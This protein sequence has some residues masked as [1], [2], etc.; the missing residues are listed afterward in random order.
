MPSS[1]G[2]F[3]VFA[4]SAD[5]APPG[6]IAWEPIAADDG[7]LVLPHEHA[8]RVRDAYLAENGPKQTAMM[9]AATSDG[10]ETEIGRRIRQGERRIETFIGSV[11]H[12]TPE[13]MSE[14][15]VEA[16]GTTEDAAPFDG[17]VPVRV[18][19][20]IERFGRRFGSRSASLEFELDHFAMLV[21]G[22]RWRTAHGREMYGF[23]RKLFR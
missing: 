21:G 8:V 6:W 15:L 12:V 1:P 2:T 5:P 9:L 14:V 16:A 23:P 19:V 22:R 3:V 20:L 7:R 4:Q 13:Q 11:P 18:D 10:E 17:L